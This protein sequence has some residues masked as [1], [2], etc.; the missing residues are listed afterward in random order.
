MMR[1]LLTEIRSAGRPLTPA[2]LAGRLGVAQDRITGMLAALRAQGMLAP[3]TV[4][5]DPS[6]CAGGSSCRSACPGPN[7]C[8]LVVDLRI[9]QQS[10]SPRLLAEGAWQPG[11]GAR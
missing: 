2:E 10:M 8:P 9:S 11:N 4:T 5:E 6:S 1:Q 3:E 7:D